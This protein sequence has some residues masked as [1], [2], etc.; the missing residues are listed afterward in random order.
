MRICLRVNDFIKYYLKIVMKRLV[1]W[2]DPH[3]VN[4]YHQGYYEIKYELQELHELK[5]S[6]C[7]KIAGLALP[8]GSFFKVLFTFHLT[9][10]RQVS[11]LSTL[12]HKTISNQKQN[13]LVYFNNVSLNLKA[14]ELMITTVFRAVKQSRYQTHVI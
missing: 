5:L 10:H 14:L 8:M 13:Y 12:P 7:H 1:E 2:F 11:V 4:Q 6:L 9:V 3:C